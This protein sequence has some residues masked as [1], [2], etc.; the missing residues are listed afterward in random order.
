MTATPDAMLDVM[1][2]AMLDAMADATLG[3]TL[4]VTLGARR[5]YRGRLMA[6]V[7]ESQAAPEW[8]PVP[9]PCD[10]PQSRP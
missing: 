5:V 3:A 6:P 8:P 9:V 2:D 1:L 7:A 4:G 10:Y